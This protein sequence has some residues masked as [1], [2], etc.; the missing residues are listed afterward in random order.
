MKSKFAENDLVKTPV[1][2]GVV[3]QIAPFPGG[4]GDAPHFE[5]LVEW[6]DKTAS[7]IH[8]DILKPAPRPAGK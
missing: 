6:P 5:Y 8:E 3:K 2:A 4:N 7:W 1:A